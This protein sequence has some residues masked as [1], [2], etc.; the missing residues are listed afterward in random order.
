[1][2]GPSGM[3]PFYCAKGWGVPQSPGWQAEARLPELRLV[4]LT[5]LELLAEPYAGR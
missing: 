1:M 2:I 5:L 3:G 4:R